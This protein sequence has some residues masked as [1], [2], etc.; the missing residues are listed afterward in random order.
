M[1]LLE[2]DEVENV[3]EAERVLGLQDG[4]TFSCRRESTRSRDCDRPFLI[5]R[6]RE[7]GSELAICSPKFTGERWVL[8]RSFNRH[9]EKPTTFGPPLSRR[10]TGDEQR[11]ITKNHL[12]VKGLI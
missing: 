3:E 4:L 2:A 1:E 7:D 9:G 12:F 6:R 10:K 5:P 8:R 11:N